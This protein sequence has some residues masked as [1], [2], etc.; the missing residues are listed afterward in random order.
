MQKVIRCE[1]L[2]GIGTVSCTEMNDAL[3]VTTKVAQKVF[4]RQYKRYVLTRVGPHVIVE[5]GRLSCQ[6]GQAPEP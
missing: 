6:G 5:R 3:S 4:T 2:T 1:P